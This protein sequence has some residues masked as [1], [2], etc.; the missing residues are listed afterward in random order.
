MGEYLNSIVFKH[1]HIINKDKYS[2][3]VLDIIKRRRIII[4]M[5]T[6]E[7]PHSR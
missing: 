2:S 1:V 5:T 6:F 3:F 4:I 7:S